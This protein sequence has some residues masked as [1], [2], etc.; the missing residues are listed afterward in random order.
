MDPGPGPMRSWDVNEPKELQKVLAVLEMIQKSFYKAVSIADLIVLAGCAG[1]EAAAR[2]GGYDVN[3]PFTPGRTDASKEM[4]YI[5]SQQY[6]NT[7]ADGF[8]NYFQP[9]VVL[10]PEEMLVDKAYLLALTAPEMTVLVG[11]LRVLG[12]GTNNSSAFTKNVGQLSNDF[13]VNLLD[14]NTIWSPSKYTKNIYEGWDRATGNKRWTGTSVDLVFGSHSILRALSEVYASEDYK[15]DFVR[16]FCAA[17]AKV[18]D[19][20]RFDVNDNLNRSRL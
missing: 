16:D 1:V 14:M 7:P 3:V 5:K 6:L 2:A 12:I 4:T 13:F 10:R 11:G 9:G 18:M 17:F 20:D 8:R 15:E 19:L